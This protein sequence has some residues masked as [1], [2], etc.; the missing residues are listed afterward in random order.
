MYARVI[1]EKIRPGAIE[2]LTAAARKGPDITKVPGFVAYYV[3]ELDANKYVTIGIFKDKESSD[4]WTK[5]ISD[6][7]KKEDLKRHLEDAPDAIAGFAGKVV[8]SRPSTP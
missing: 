8:Y 5:M 6:H 2:A 1:R 3:M 7:A 4:R